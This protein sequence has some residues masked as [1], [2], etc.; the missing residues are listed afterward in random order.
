MIE[1]NGN[2]SS[3]IVH[4]VDPNPLVVPLVPLDPTNAAE[5]CDQSALQ[6]EQLEFIESFFLDL[7]FGN[8]LYEHRKTRLNDRSLVEGYSRILIE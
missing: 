5:K 4:I 8:I 7:N 1:L 2:K 6:V 3:A